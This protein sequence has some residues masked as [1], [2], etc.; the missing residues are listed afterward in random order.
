[1]INEEFKMTINLLIEEKH[2][3]MA[4]IKNNKEQKDNS[5]IFESIFK[6]DNKIKEYSSLIEK[7]N[8][9]NKNEPM[10]E[11]KQETANELMKNKNIN[12]NT[13]IGVNKNISKINNDSIENKAANLN[14][15][16]KKKQIKAINLE[17]KIINNILKYNGKTEIIYYNSENN[18]KTIYTYKNESKN[19]YFYQCNKRPKCAGLSKFN[20]IT[21]E[22]FITKDCN[23]YSG[24][25]KITYEEFEKLVE[26]KEYI[27]I[28]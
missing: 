28:L 6:I 19:I 16:L 5:N 21:N 9:F 7:K 15:K 24:H 14:K 22:F 18:F 26:N 4:I 25:N 2:R 17:D 1:M 10:A 20:K 12:M 11:D 27:Y 13:G 23:N 8:Y 3:L